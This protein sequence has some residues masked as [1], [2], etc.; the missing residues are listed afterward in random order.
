MSH[1]DSW[2]VWIIFG[3]LLLILEMFSFSFFLASFGLAALLTAF[4]AA[5]DASFTWQI[6]SF[7]AVS[8]ALLALL[9]PL[10]RGMYAKS[11]P[12]RTN[13]DALSGQIGLVIEQINDA[14]APGRVKVGGEE[15]RALSSDGSLLA[16]GARVSIIA[17]DGATLMVRPLE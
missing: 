3:I 7:A 4:V 17:V 11:D 5:G 9:R 12:Q 14:A 2:H 16:V 15:W 13:V 10:A 6:A 8:T 1:L